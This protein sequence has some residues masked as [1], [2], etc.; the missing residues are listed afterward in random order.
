MKK[1]VCGVL[2]CLALLSG[3]GPTQPEQETNFPATVTTQALLDS[4]AF[5]E[6]LEELDLETALMFFWLNG[7][8]AQYE[9]SKVYCSTGATSEAVA[10][11]CFADAQ[12]AAEVEAALN[13]WVANQIE[14]EREYRPA[15]MEKLEHAIVQVRGNSALLVVAADWDKAAAAIPGAE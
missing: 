2:C 15:E 12:Q 5:S 4:G 6:A 9:G 14:A 11:I 3:C 1:L 8:M 13:T 10:V 7:D